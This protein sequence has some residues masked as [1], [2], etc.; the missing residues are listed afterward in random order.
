MRTKKRLFCGID[1]SQHT[2]D[3]YFKDELAQE[4]SLQV[5]NSKKGFQLLLDMAPRN[6]QFLMEATGV[7]HWELLFFL[8][9][10]KRLFSILNPLQVKHYKQMLMERNKTDEVDAK[11]I[12]EFGVD[13]HPPLY[14]LGD[15]QLLECRGMNATVQQLTKQIS[16][17]KNQLHSLSKLPYSTKI[18]MKTLKRVLKKVEDERELLQKRLLDLLKQNC[19]DTLELVQSIKGIGERG[20]VELIVQT[21]NF[22]RTENYRQLISFAGLSPVEHLSGTSIHRPTRICKKG[23]KVL[24]T[25]LYMC[26]LNAMQTNPHCRALYQRLLAKGKKKKVA[27]IAVCN[28]LLRLV[29]GVIRNREKY[30]EE[31]GRTIA[32]ERTD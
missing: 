18:A 13:F 6:C 7:Y 23:G 31:Y 29:F 9:Q 21:D 25:A 14:Q 27:I 16:Q 8:H 28:K 22:S 20:A 15:L 5:P 32:S 10:R 4:F 12:Y 2:L 11:R 1:V 17:L 19:A 24:R 30:N 26:A 3:V